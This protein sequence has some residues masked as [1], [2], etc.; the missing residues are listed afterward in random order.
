VACLQRCIHL[1]DARQSAP[2]ITRNS[3]RARTIHCWSSAIHQRGQFTSQVATNTETTSLSFVGRHTKSDETYWPRDEISVSHGAHWPATT[4]EM[5]QLNSRTVTRRACRSL[6]L[7]VFYIVRYCWKLLHPADYRKGT[8]KYEDDGE[9]YERATRYNYSSQEKFAM[10][11]ILSL[12]KG[13]Q[14]QMNRL[15]ETF[16]EAICSTTYNELQ[17]F[18]Q[19][20]IR[21]MIK[22]VTQKKRDLTKRYVSSS[23]RGALF[24]KMTPMCCLASWLPSEIHVLI[25]STGV[26]KRIRSKKRW[27]LD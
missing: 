14:L 19:I 11:E 9:E 7:D 25:G 20:H 5:D 13:L 4:I 6:F 24:E 22:K 16:H 15:T 1:I 18:V 26:V 8:S 17:S 23:E 10:V 3:R 21:D 12:I 27:H 2:A